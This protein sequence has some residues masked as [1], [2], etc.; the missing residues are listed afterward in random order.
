MSFSNS[1]QTKAAEYSLGKKITAWVQDGFGDFSITDIYRDLDLVLQEDR[2][3]CQQIIK[4]LLAGNEIQTIGTRRGW[5]RRIDRTLNIIEWQNADM[6]EFNIRFPFKLHRQVK[7]FPKSLIA[8]S[9]EKNTGK[10]AICLNIVREN[11]NCGVP[12]Y[13]FSSEMLAPEFRVRLRGFY[14]ELTESDWNFTAVHRTSDFADVIQPDAVNIIDFLEIYDKFWMIGQDM[15]EI[16][17]KLD[18]GIAIVCVQKSGGSE[19]GR[20]GSFLIEKP[21]LTISLSKRF[22]EYNE[23]AGAT[24]KVTNAKFPR[25]G[26]ENVNGKQIDYKIRNGCELIRESEWYFER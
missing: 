8:I 3:L 26:A 24:L 9:G 13:Y 1:T 11:Q 16:F 5:Y 23:L 21:R 2:E 20:G 12:I 18:N 22:N 19:H 6:A 10:S 4:G 17:N 25:D 15:T 14:P 7:V